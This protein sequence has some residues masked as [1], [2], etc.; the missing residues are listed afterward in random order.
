MAATKRRR[1]TNDYTDDGGWHLD[2]RIPIALI[3][4]LVLQ[5]V[6][7]VVMFRDVQN[8]V[9]R[10]QTDIV[11][12]REENKERAR[13]LEDLSA[14]KRDLINIKENVVR[15]ERTVDKILAY[16]FEVAAQRAAN[17]TGAQIPTRP[18]RRAAR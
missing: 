12:L 3:T 9:A 18:S 5:G 4:G 6:A 1:R 7:I 10:A 13:R 11:V 2:R 8:D 15:M 16:Q 17:A 14:I